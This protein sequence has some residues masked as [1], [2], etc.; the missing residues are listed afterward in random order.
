MMVQIYW[1]AVKIDKII[2]D[3]FLPIEID[4]KQE[5]EIE[6]GTHYLLVSNH[7][8]WID[9]II[10]QNIFYKKLPPLKFLVKWEIMFIPIVGLICWAFEYPFLKR[11][12]KN[13]MQKNTNNIYRDKNEIEKKLKKCSNTPCNFV[14][15]MEEHRFNQWR[16]D[17]QNN[18][19][20]NLLKPKLGGFSVISDL[21]SNQIINII[22][23][24]IIYEK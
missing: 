14:N 18:E 5:N 1:L 15:F 9:I 8:S 20:H 22:D 19:F 2:L 11:Y 21:F 10:L 12:S 6:S 4:Y 24:T 13:K 23:V 17:I 16:K 7:Q 3:T